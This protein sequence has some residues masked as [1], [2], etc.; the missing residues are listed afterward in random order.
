MP[1]RLDPALLERA[2]R[3]L[4]RRDPVIGGV[5]RRVGPCGIR[6]RGDPYRMLVRSVM[7][8]QL[9]GAAAR[10][11]VGRVCGRF[12]GRI[13]RP[14]LLLAAPEGELRAAGL[15]RQKIATLRAVAAAFAEGRLCNRRLRR[16][17]DAAVVEAVTEIKG[18]GEWTA[19]MLLMFCLGS[20]ASR[21]GTC[22]SLSESVQKD[23]AE[24]E[25]PTRHSD[26]VQIPR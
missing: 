18:I 7:Y 23:V 10:A 24:A 8:Q 1:A 3:S 16:M 2:R 20:P 19:H 13:P 9:A 14:E 12:G 5:I 21:P 4:R 6:P 22:G 26:S 17:D 11:I 15:S 25:P